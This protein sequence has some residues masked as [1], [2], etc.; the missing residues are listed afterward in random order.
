MKIVC[1]FILIGINLQLNAQYNTTLKVQR[2]TIGSTGPTTLLNSN[3]SKLLPI[4]SIGQESVIG[5]FSTTKTKVRQGYI[6]SINLNS[7][8]DHLNF[9]FIAYPNPFNDIIT[10]VFLEKISTQIHIEIYDL[11]RK[12]IYTKEFESNQKISLDLLSFSNSIYTL[13]VNAN[14]KN[15]IKNIVKN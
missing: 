3:E 12:I 6:Q 7:N 11:T 14:N 15:F 1:F 8:P 10:L 4:Q 5:K 9:D 13:K 2:S